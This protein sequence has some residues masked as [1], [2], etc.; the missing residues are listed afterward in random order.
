MDLLKTQCHHGDLYTLENQ[1]H[2]S[3]YM[4]IW[5]S[6]REFHNVYQGQN[7]CIKAFRPEAPSRGS[8]VNKT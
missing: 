2:K 8:V 1:D 7:N 6:S 5:Q 3:E 4:F